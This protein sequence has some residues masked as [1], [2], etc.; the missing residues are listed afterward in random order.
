MGQGQL[1]LSSFFLKSGLITRVRVERM[2]GSREGIWNEGWEVAVSQY[3]RMTE[4]L[5]G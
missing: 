2:V 5:S 4:Q 3:S 1:V